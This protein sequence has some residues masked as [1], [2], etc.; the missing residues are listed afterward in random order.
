MVMV[1]FSISSAC[2]TSQSVNIQMKS[3][4]RRIPV[5]GVAEYLF[6]PKA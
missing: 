3:I 5:V 6:F 1:L 2:M 4:E